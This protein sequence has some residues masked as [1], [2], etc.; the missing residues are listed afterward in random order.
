MWKYLLVVLVFNIVVFG[1]IDEAV[2]ADRVYHSERLSLVATGAPGHPELRSGHVVN[3]HPNG[4]VVGAVENY[5][6]NG[7]KADTPYDV[8]LT[9]YDGGCDGGLLFAMTT[10]QLATNSHGNGIARFVFSAEDL[11]AFSGLTVG[12]SWTLENGGTVA[13][14]TDCTI[15][16]LD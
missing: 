11:A 7:A 14:E 5:Q 4:P 10:T 6:V 9:V 2:R 13:Y 1:V 12:A 8:V 3:I 15:V 16:V